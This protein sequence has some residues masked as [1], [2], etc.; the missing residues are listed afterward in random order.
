MYIVA[1]APS[2]KSDLQPKIHIFI[3]Y[4]EKAGICHPLLPYFVNYCRCHALFEVE[5]FPQP[6]CTI[7]ADY[8]EVLLQMRKVGWLDDRLWFLVGVGCQ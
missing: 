6:D 7:I 5:I 8:K 2:H 3:Y 1:N 4:N